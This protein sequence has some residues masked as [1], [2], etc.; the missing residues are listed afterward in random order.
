M[1][2]ACGS[3]RL[4]RPSTTGDLLSRSRED[5][6]AN[7]AAGIG[8]LRTQYEHFPEILDIGERLKLG[9]AG[10][11]CGRGYVNSALSIY[12][13]RRSPSYPPPGESVTREGVKPQLAAARDDGRCCDFRKTW[14]Y[15]D[16]VWQQYLDFSRRRLL[17]GP[18][19][20]RRRHRFV[21]CPC[22]FL[23]IR[24]HARSNSFLHKGIKAH[25]RA[26]DSRGRAAVAYSGVRVANR[27]KRRRI[28][29]EVP[30]FHSIKESVHHVCSTCTEGNNIESENK[31]R[32]TG[33]KR[34]DS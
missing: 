26:V 24:R 16:R 30:P 29:A 28:I 21:Q 7:L 1:T 11:H 3:R 25:R 22:K 17:G 12:R 19:Q 20:S 9:T 13:Q 18:G 14:A 31:R 10:Y 2:F 8:Y 5:A 32:G 4:H 34:P 33:G 6:Q 27:L 23:A 15:V